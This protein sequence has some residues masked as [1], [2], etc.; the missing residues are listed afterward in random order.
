LED[1]NRAGELVLDSINPDARVVWGSKINPAL[2]GKI[3]A[4]V[5]VAG[6]E[7]P[8]LMAEKKSVTVT[9]PAASKT[10]VTKISSKK[11]A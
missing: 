6:V 5:V 8:F 1:V 9:K 11:K 7:S 3:R 4:T 2:D 10:T